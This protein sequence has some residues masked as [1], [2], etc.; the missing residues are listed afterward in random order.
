MDGM[1]VFFV[2]IALRVAVVYVP[3]A[4]PSTTRYNGISQS[5]ERIKEGH[6]QEK[7]IANQRQ[8]VW[9]LHDS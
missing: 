9:I 4:A 7:S 8:M 3:E 1:I 6:K 2:V 5:P